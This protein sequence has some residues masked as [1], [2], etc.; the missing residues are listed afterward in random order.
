M[1]REELHKQVSSSWALILWRE[2]SP[3]L[4]VGSNSEYHFRP[5]VVDYISFNKGLVVS[6]CVA[7]NPN[8]ECDDLVALKKNIE[9]AFK[10][11][12]KLSCTPNTNCTG[13]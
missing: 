10:Y 4:F 13:I 1:V 9:S 6:Y 12:G 11:L 5:N 2:S 3:S 8:P 7:Q